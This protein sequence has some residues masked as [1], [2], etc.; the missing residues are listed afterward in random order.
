MTQKL[1]EMDY[2]QKG[3]EAYRE[4]KPES[5]NPYERNHHDNQHLL[6]YAVWWR[7]GWESERRAAT[8]VG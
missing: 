7:Q 3:A 2:F 6:S 5:A 8:G 1:T 4:G